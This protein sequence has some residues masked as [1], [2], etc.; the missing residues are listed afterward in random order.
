M[1]I[2]EKTPNEPQGGEIQSALNPLSAAP[3]AY[4]PGD[5]ARSGYTAQPGYTVQQ[6]GY[7]PKQQ[8]YL[9]Q[10]GY[11]LQT[12]STVSMQP[13]KTVIVSPLPPRPPSYLGLSIFSCLFCFWP[14]GFAALCYSNSVDSS[15]DEG[16]YQRALSRS[17]AAKLLNIFSIICGL[18]FIAVIAIARMKAKTTSDTYDPYN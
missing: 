5:T 13:N 7:P 4:T 10:P 18:I 15:Y 1:D 17:N 16:D 8:P 14:L 6:P 12:F 3:P 9:A 2:K 11:P